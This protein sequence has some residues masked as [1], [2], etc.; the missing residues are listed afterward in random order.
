MGLR[1]VQNLTPGRLEDELLR[2]NLRLIMVDS[3]GVA[4]TYKEAGAVRPKTKKPS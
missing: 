3:G 1:L 4:N 2:E